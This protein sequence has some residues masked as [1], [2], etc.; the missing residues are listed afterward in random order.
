VLP[1]GL[2]KL[3]KLFHLIETRT[4]NLP[5]C[6]IV[7][8]LLSYRVP[9]ILSCS[10]EHSYGILKLSFDANLLE[11]LHLPSRLILYCL[12]AL[13]HLSR[14]SELKSEHGSLSE[15][16]LR[17]AALNGQPIADVRTRDPWFHNLIP[18]GK[19]PE[20]KSVKGG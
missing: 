16:F 18:N 8:Q 2:G 17:C 19:E 12:R 5:A 15:G 10:G 13:G 9:R 4:R 1:E 11:Y 20:R 6:S 7:P 3:K 14:G